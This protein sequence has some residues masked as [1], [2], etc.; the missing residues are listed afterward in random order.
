MKREEYLNKL[1]LSLEGDEFGPVEEAIAYFNELLDDRMAEEGMDEESAV[2]SLEAPELVAK[3]LRHTQTEKPKTEP[4]TGFVPGIR[5]IQVKPSQ[6]RS[7]EVHDRN[8]RLILRGWDQDE[9]RIRHPETEK[10]RYDFTLDAGALKLFRQP[11]ELS[12][13]LFQFERLSP[14]MREVTLDVP[15]ELAAEVNLR[16]SNSRLSAEGVHIWGKLVLRTSNSTLR[17]KDLSAKSIQAQTSNSSIGLG[18]VKA[19]QDLIVTTSNGVIGAQIASAGGLLRFATSNSSIQVE[20]LSAQHFELT[21]SNGSIRGQLPGRMAD[22]AIT[23]ATSNSKS[24]LPR[25]QAGGPGSLT[26]R[27]SNG[28]IDLVFEQD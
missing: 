5:N 18:T 8:T 23:S 25:Q 1:K 7:I 12:L 10:I 3:Q 9:I 4:A 26:A 22:Y 14:E 6:V 15:H 16:T 27:T 24:S 21:T 2:A 19:E 11:A 17:L 28:R 20:G 13:L